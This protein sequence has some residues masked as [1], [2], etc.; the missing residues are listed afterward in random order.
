VSEPCLG[1]Q[2]ERRAAGLL[3]KPRPCGDAAAPGVCRRRSWP[4]AP[5]PASR[6]SP[7][8]ARPSQFQGNG[9]P[10]GPTERRTSFPRIAGQTRTRREGSCCDQS[11]SAHR[12][13]SAMERGSGDRS[14]HH[15]AG[16]RVPADPTGPSTLDDL[17]RSASRSDMASRLGPEQ[18]GY[19]GLTGQP[20]PRKNPRCSTRRTGSL[21]GGTNCL[22]PR[23]RPPDRH[24][25]TTWRT[26]KHS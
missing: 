4:S 13:C 14:A 26:L 7:G 10:L 12:C 25:M 8:S 5:E 24:L 21:D 18:T 19:D 2:E 23:S 20:P 1:G 11:G 6:R 17:L 15:S 3:P 16:D 22:V 9:M